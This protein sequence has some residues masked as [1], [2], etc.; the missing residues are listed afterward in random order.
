MALCATTALAGAVPRLCVRGARGRFGGSGRYRVL[1]LS[2]FPLPAPRVRRCVWRAV[3]SGCPLPSLAGTPFHVVCAF[4][5]L[6]PVARLVVPA[7]PFRV[8]ALALSR[9]PLPP[10]LGGVACAPRVVPALGAG[11]AVRRGPCPS[12]CPVPVPCSVW[13]VWGG[14][15]RSR[16]PPTWLGVVQVAAGRPPGGVPS[17]VARGVWG[18]ALPL[19]RLPAHW[20]GCR[21]PR[22][23]CCGRGHAGVGALLCPLGRHALW[24]LRAAGRVRGVHVLG[25]GLGGGGGVRRTPRLCGRGGACGAG[26]RSASFRPSAFPGQATKRVS[27]ALCCP[28]G[29][30]P[31]IPLRF[32]LTRLLWVRSVRRPGA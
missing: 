22:S 26:G 19:P 8:C 14:A 3:P 2:L 25:G 18:H 13:R 7:C 30:W 20:V 10:P 15:V 31:P 23:T 11:R 4:R 1:C 21:V 29:A 9:C 32:V 27:L 24:G 12:A 5:A 16:F 17:T 6:G 28:W